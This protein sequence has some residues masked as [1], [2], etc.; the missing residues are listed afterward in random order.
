MNTSPTPHST[1]PE[2]SAEDLY[3]NAPCGYLSALP[4]G[5]IVRVNQTFLMLTGHTRATLLASRVQELLTR[6]VRV[7]YETHIATL[8][9]LHGSVKEIACD[10]VRVDSSPLPVLMNAVQVCD[11]AGQPVLLRFTFFDATERRRY[12]TD[13]L[14][15]SQRAERFAVIVEGSADAILS[16]GAHGT[17]ET[18]NAAAEQLFGYTAGEAVGFAAQDLIRLDHGVELHSLLT[19]LRAGRAVRRELGCTGRD[20]RR[21]EVAATLTPHLEPPGELTGVS[22]VLRDITERKRVEE[23]V[24]RLAAI[25]ASSYD[26]IIGKDLQGTITSWNRGAEVVFGYTAEEMIGQSI[27][28]LIPLERRAEEAE[29]LASV[30]RGESKRHFETVR[31]RKDGS[32]VEISVTVSPI[33]DASGTIVG[34][35]KVVRDITEQ[36]QA[37]RVL[38]ATEKRFR[39]TFENAAVGIAHVSPTGQWL[40]VNER[41]CQIT[42]YEREELL[43]KTF[44]DITYPEDLDADVAHVKRLL[45]GKADSYTMEK[46]YL[47]KDGSLV[48]VNLTVSGVRTAEG[49]IEFFIAV[50]EDISERKRAEEELQ[51]SQERTHLATM[52]TGVGIWEWDV[53]TNQIRWD[54]E[55]FRIYGVAPT[56]DG[57][58]SYSTWSDAVVPE[59]LLQQEL[60]LRDTVSRLA[61]G[62]REF[63]IRHRDSGEL[64][65]IESVEVVRTDAQGGAN[66]VVGT[67]LDVTERKR[68]QREIQDLNTR[69]Q[70][71]VAESHH[72][73]KNNLQV[74]SAMIELQ[75]HHGEEPVS[76]ENR[77]RLLTHIRTLA[78]LHDLLTMETK[79]GENLATFSPRTAL[80]KLLPMLSAAMGG[81][82]VLCDAESEIRLPLKL[83]TSFV[84]LVNELVSNAHKHGAGDIEVRL[85]WEEGVSTQPRVRLEVRDDGPGFPPDFDPLVSANTGLE[86]IESLG[87]WDLGGEVHYGNHEGGGAVVTVLFIGETNHYEARSGSRFQE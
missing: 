26:A 47:R 74:L 55:M 23:T 64:R 6:T 15:A 70:R 43:T 20:G 78:S 82:Q 28:R 84:L 31:V 11:E 71:G 9:R 35:S 69:L 56:T 37:E 45:V 19:E 7:F 46:R 59:D 4:D 3:E 14:R 48:W 5:R 30:A 18:W 33:R 52:A 57:I 83:A 62:T 44:Q 27:L 63:R 80:E 36:K 2:E 86:L 65:D 53:V 81:R 75:S 10:L 58:V 76:Q 38:H 72:R 87:N 32:F 85:K 17:V 13:L 8:L 61:R 42:Q 22:V 39:G 66:W 73:I 41:I 54:A 25:V 29:I 1:L 60:A 79:I 21:V 34:A 51:A 68:A 50:V 12:E 40:R 49:A 16:L 24:G 67:N 77:N